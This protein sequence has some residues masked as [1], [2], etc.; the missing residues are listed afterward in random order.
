MPR[1]LTNRVKRTPQSEL[2]DDRYSY[3]GLNQA[4]PNLGDPAVPGEII[5]VG[6][7]YRSYLFLK[8]REKDIG[9]L[10]VED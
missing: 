6:T 4:E 7:Q 8:D 10:L 3:I 5:P 9:F 1:Y 2:S